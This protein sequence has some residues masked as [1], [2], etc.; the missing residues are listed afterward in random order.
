MVL[1]GSMFLKIHKLDKKL[2]LQYVRKFPCSRSIIKN[3]LLKE[4]DTVHFRFPL[5]GFSR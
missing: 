3:T 5:Q 1:I 4:P 2:I